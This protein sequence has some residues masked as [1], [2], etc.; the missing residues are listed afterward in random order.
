MKNLVVKITDFG[1]VVG[2]N[3][4][5]IQWYMITPEYTAPEVLTGGKS[6]FPVDIWALA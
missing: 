1:T 2:N 5:N 3:E 6:S 4:H